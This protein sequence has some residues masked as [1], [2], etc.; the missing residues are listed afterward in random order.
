MA[1]SLAGPAVGVSVAAVLARFDRSSSE[2]L[3]TSLAGEIVRLTREQA[4]LSA[5]LVAVEQLHVVLDRLLPAANADVSGGELPKTVQID[6]THS[7]LDGIGF[8]PLEFDPAGAP[9]RW[10]GP[11]AQFSLGFFVDRRYGGKFKLSFQRFAASVSAS[12]MRCMLDGKPTEFAVHDLRNGY[13]VSGV[14]PPR[15]DHGASVLTFICPATASPA[16]LGQSADT[17]QLGLAFQKLT[18]RSTPAP[19]IQEISAEV[20]PETA[21]ESARPV[22]KARQAA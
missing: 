16:Q 5:R 11:G 17:R 13:E 22:R 18:A 12:F 2:K 20:I 15:A 9:S 21:L 1:I 10:T 4:D 19:E 6:A 3:L 8:Y 14:L 7:M